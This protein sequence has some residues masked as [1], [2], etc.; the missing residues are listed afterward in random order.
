MGLRTRTSR[1]KYWIVFGVVHG[2]VVILVKLMRGLASYEV[3]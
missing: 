3:K 2:V 1:Q